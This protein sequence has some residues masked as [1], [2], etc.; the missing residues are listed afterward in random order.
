MIVEMEFHSFAFSFSLVPNSSRSAHRA[1]SL[2]VPVVNMNGYAPAESRL[3]MKSAEN[4]RGSLRDDTAE[5]VKTEY[6]LSEMKRY[7]TPRQSDGENS[8][9]SDLEYV[10]N[11]ENND[12]KDD[13]RTSRL[14]ETARR[15]LVLGTIRPSRTFYKDLPEGDVEYL[16]EYF[17]R[18]REKQRTM[19][20]DEINAELT[21]K[22][23]EYKPKV[24]ESCS[25]FNE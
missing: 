19:T 12:E 15:L 3:P 11:V 18:M 22:Y 8:S 2:T 10:Q 7:T 23:V 9:L 14:N 16:M 1:H 4:R 21:K 20:S 24:C 5:T 17:R 25:S 13:Q 6:K